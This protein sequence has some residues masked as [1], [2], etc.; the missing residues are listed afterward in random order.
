MGLF[1]QKPQ[2]ERWFT[3]GNGVYIECFNG[4]YHKLTRSASDSVVAR[5][6]CTGDAT[7]YFETWKPITK[8][9]YIKQAEPIKAS[10]QEWH[11]EIPLEFLFECGGKKYF[12]CEAGRLPAG[13]WF[14]SQV[15]LDEIG[16][17]LNGDMI[18]A[19]TGAMTEALNKG[20][21]KRV[22][23]LINEVETRRKLLA[24]VDAIT[25][26]AA[27]KIFEEGENL[28]EFDLDYQKRKIAHW[29]EHMGDSFFLSKPIKMLLPF[30]DMSQDEWVQRLAMVKKL[31]E[32][33][34]LS[35][36]ARKLKERTQQR[37]S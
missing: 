10:W 34:L 11:T 23:V 28:A 26:F 15:I 22:G 37:K 3:N 35:R 16:M 33:G 6:E 18:D 20:D 9:Q 24:D 1:K 12:T 27:V 13:R 7:Q 14:H 31:D 19:F 36:F 2:D 17:G 30:S 5:I 25:R 21:M 4:Y 29:R 32:E 8:A